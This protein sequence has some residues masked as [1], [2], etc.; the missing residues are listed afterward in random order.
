MLQGA[1]RA[2]NIAA[3]RQFWEELKSSFKTTKKKTKDKDG[4]F[5]W[6]E[7]YVSCPAGLL[8]VCI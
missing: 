4:F 5:G 8:S 6:V 7:E 1:K 2:Q 3:L